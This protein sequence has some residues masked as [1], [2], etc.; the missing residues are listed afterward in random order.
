MCTHLRVREQSFIAARD[1]KIQ[2][3]QF[4]EMLMI[5]DKIGFQVKDITAAESKL[6][7][8]REVP[9][10]LY[11]MVNQATIKADKLCKDI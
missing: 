8:K 5:F 7:A 9:A 10:N 3:S 1:K 11:T 6:L 4:S 2:K